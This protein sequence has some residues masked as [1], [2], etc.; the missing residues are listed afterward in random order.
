MPSRP[1]S[2]ERRYI[3]SS[4]HLASPGAEELS[5][6][7]YGLIVANNAFSRWI[8][9]CMKAAGVSDLSALD[10]LVLHNLYHRGRAKRLADLCLVLGIDDTHVVTYALKKLVQ[11]GLV[12]RDKPSKEVF[13][14]VTNDGEA[15]CRRYREIR[16][17]CLLTSFAQSHKDAAE[18]LSG[19][20]RHLRNL[21][22]LYD[23]AA[24]AASSL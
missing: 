24:R 13:Y 12:A 23:Q 14:H 4:A 11:L 20:A 2:K 18:L 21:S 9:H 3:V 7:E 22:G 15:A 1:P 6:F 5:E 10:V 8:V 19:L 16:D 17:Q